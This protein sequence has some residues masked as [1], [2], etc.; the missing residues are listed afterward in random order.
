MNARLNGLLLVRRLE[1]T[2]ASSAL[3][4]LRRIAP[5]ILGMT[6]FF[7]MSSSQVAASGYSPAYH[8][9]RGA[10][11]WLTDPYGLSVKYITM[12]AIN[13]TSAVDWQGV[14]WIPALYKQ[15]ANGTWN[16]VKWNDHWTT[17]MTSETGVW[18]LVPIGLNGGGTGQGFSIPRSA[19]GNYRVAILYRWFARPE[20]G[21]AQ[22]DRFEWLSGP[23]YANGVGAALYPYCGFSQGT[24]IIGGTSP[25]GG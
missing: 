7:G 8:D 15:A 12:Y 23:Y 1:A 25:F 2:V 21:L 24:T 17:G 3:A 16:F 10:D 4:T 9:D 6:L 19:Q 5:P 20:I 18:N 13:V 14:G 11:C 22:Q